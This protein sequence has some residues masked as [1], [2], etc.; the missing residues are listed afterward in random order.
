M[1]SHYEATGP[2]IVSET[3]SALQNGKTRYGPVSG[4]RELRQTLSG[5]FDGYDAENIIITNGSKQ[6]L[7]QAVQVLCD[8]VDEVIIPS[9]CWV[10]FSEQI[11]LAGAEPV[12]VDTRFHQLDGPAIERS[13]NERTKA[14]IINSPNNPTGAV[15]GRKDLESIVKL[16]QAHDL[17]LIS[18]EAYEIFVYDG[19]K[20]ISLFDFPEVRKRLIVA[21]SFSK[22]H[23]MTGFR[24]GYAVAPREIIRAMSR[25]QSHLTGNVCTFAQY[26]ALAATRL[27]TCGFEPWINRLQ[28]KRD[29][30]MH[31]P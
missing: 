25:L 26:G 2:K 31:S 15:Y 14:I 23:C 18:D 3:A 7:Y 1:E 10:S 21:R 29:L 24:I 30:T 4:L 6:A 20:H 16:A 8:P 19:L 12:L 5:N 17:F 13:I 9:P 11:K 22:T 27:D 28:K